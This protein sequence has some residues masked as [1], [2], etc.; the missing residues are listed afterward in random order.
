MAT[1]ELFHLYAEEAGWILDATAGGERVVVEGRVRTPALP[2][3]STLVVWYVDAPRIVTLD[4]AHG[5]LS[6]GEPRPTL[7]C[8]ALG[9]GRAHVA[10]T[11][12]LTWTPVGGGAPRTHAI[13]I[14]VDAALIT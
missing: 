10:G 12:A 2:G 11:L 6:A 8:T 1:L 7:A 14:A 3:P 9:A 5:T 13:A 4:G